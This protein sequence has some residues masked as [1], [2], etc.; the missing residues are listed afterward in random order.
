MARE[1]L[2]ARCHLT[3]NEREALLDAFLSVCH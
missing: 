3:N 1:T 2:F